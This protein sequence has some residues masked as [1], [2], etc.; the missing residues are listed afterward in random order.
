MRWILVLSLAACSAQT[1]AT[2]ISTVTHKVDVLKNEESR[3]VCDCACPKQ[4]SV[5]DAA[6][7]LGGLANLVSS[8]D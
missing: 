8:N 5:F 1:P 2:C 4:R 6:G 3:T 7:I